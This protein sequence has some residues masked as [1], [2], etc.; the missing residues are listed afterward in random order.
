MATVNQESSKPEMFKDKEFIDG[1]LDQSFER[2]RVALN[3]EQVTTE[4]SN[5]IQGIMVDGMKVVSV[6]GGPTAGKGT[7]VKACMKKLEEAEMKSDTLATDDYCV[8]TR[9]WRWTREKEDPLSLKDF[10][11][12]NA[13]LEAI[14]NV[15]DD[16]EEVAVPTYDEETGLAIEAGEENYKHKIGRSDVIFVEGDFDAVERPDLLVYIDVPAEARMQARIAR[17]LAKRG[18]TDSE[19]IADS[20]R[21]RY[22]KQ[23]LP[24]TLP[25][26]ERASL[27]LRV[28]PI[29]GEWQYDIYQAKDGSSIAR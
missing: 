3:S 29:P 24:Y 27:V 11:L 12:L 9:E 23:Y 25:A 8:G 5:I 2:T 19:K 22:E 26:I 10:A 1:V 14:R 16:Y 28:N 18:E 21:S 20:F 7:L 4:L 15:D 6:I 13:H 17:D